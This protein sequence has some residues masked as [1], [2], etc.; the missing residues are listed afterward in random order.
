MSQ[1]AQARAPEVTAQVYD[2]P[3]GDAYVL[4]I[5]VADAKADQIGV[6]ATVGT[7]TVTVRSQSR[8]FEFPMDL[9]TDNV[10]AELRQGLL[11]IQAPKA[12]AGKRRMVR[13]EQVV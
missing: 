13:V 7:I 9:D 3:G 5:P 4:E 6:E 11:R 12:L 1:P 8:V 2:A 10:R